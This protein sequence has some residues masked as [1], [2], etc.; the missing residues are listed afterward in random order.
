MELKSD[1]AGLPFKEHRVEVSWRHTMNYAA[2]IGDPHP[3]FFDDEAPDGVLAP[4][5]FPVA[6]TWP[7]TERLPQYL[8]Q[9]GFPTEVLMTQVHAT[10]HLQLHRRLRAGETLVI[11]GRIAAIAPHRAGTYVVLCYEATDPS[12]APV[13]TEHMGGILRG[14]SCAGG[15]K[16]VQ[17]LTSAPA[18]TPKESPISDSLIPVDPLF[19][20]VYD[21]CSRIFFPIHTSRRF[22]R[23]VGLPGIIVQ[24]T[25]TLALAVKEI[26]LHFAEGDPR[27]ILA[28]GARFS[29]MVLPGTSIRLQTLSETREREAL[30][31]GFQVLTD[32]GTTAIRDG[33][34]SL[35]PGPS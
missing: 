16:G 17:D 22:A 15:P 26:T 34:V 35:S 23:S 20:F 13:F 28:V 19:P 25:A 8:Q 7:I 18:L 32:A 33:F 4:P 5:L 2:A 14:V 9:R 30:H 11:R 10:E 3:L 29:G 21:G 24:G 27:R 6:L 1:F 12:G 31:V